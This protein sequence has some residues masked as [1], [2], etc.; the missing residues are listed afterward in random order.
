MRRGALL[1]LLFL[2]LT[3]LMAAPW[4]LHPASRVVID[5]PDTH[6]FLWTLG[7]D[8][9]ALATDPRHIFD[10]NIYHPMANTLAY[11]ENLIGSALLAAPVI[12]ATGDLVLA[13]NLV[14]LLSCALCGIGAYVLAK[15]VGLGTP[16]ALITGL[17][18]A[19][20]PTRF[21]RMSQAFLTA[22]QWMPLCLAFLH[23]Y[24]RTGR[25]RDLR[26][27]ILF[28]SLQALTSGHGA[29]MLIV[30]IA[31]L[32]VVSVACG[33][34]VALVRRVRDAGVSGVLLALPAVLVLLPYRQAHAEVGLDRSLDTW[35]VTPESFI[36]SPTIVHR[37]LLGLVTSRDPN[38][39]ASAFLF[40][41]YLVLVLAVAA[42]WPAPTRADAIGPDARVLRRQAWLHALLAV[43]SLAFFVHGPLDLWP[44][45]RSWPG[46]N[47]I[48]VPSRFMILTTLALAVLAGIG[49]ERLVASWAPRRATAAAVL[50][51][52]LLLGEYATHPFTG[53]PFVVPRPAIVVWLA[54]QPGPAV[55][56][57][58]PIPRITDAGP[59]E[60]FETAAML[61]STLRWQK[62]VHGYS[63][64]RP[65]LHDRLFREL[66]TFPDE[67]SLASL[68]D[69]GVTHVVVHR[70]LYAAEVWPDVDRRL[71]SAPGLRFVHEEPDGLVFEVVRPAM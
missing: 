44:W 70:L 53:V 62:T 11:S 20:A 24:L 35:A 69:L 34:P 42:L 55:V 61:H 26:L 66:Y 41:G 21:Y 10:A 65:G 47:F 17:V 63:G 31:L 4:S 68:R 33:E 14:L 16:A 1:A 38:E 71:R 25:A 9:H 2:G 37:W 64:F 43:L 5:N 59:F 45:V 22:V 18:F 29:V 39:T 54:A 27:A 52:A 51:G 13:L 12:W 7:W 46:L 23:G 30:A 58:V 28:F 6:L 15:R 36:A 57:E 48:R 60:R 50:A 32:G 19:F 8:A 67:T 40:P 56:A 3:V 49:F